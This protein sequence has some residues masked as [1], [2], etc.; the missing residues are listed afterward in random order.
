MCLDDVEAANADVVR[1][2]TCEQVVHVKQ[3]DVI[4]PKMEIGDVTVSSTSKNQRAY[5]TYKERSK[6]MEIILTSSSGLSGRWRCS[7]HRKRIC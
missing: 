1:V 6:K 2:D 7:F 4:E 3:V 5:V